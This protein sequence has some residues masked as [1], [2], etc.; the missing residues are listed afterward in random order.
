[1]SSAVCTFNAGLTNSTGFKNFRMAMPYVSTPSISQAGGFV[2]T[3]SA[4]FE[5]THHSEWINSSRQR[6]SSDGG[7]VGWT[8][9][10]HAQTV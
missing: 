4:V 1:L 7:K 5:E 2:V 10:A 6:F 8:S 3:A 9:C